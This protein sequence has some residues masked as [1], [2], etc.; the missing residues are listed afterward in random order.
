[1]PK[2]TA[3]AVLELHSQGRRGETTKGCGHGLVINSQALDLHEQ[4]LA[5]K[6]GTPA[7]WL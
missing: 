3:G 7:K 4:N 5:P 1:M 6:F 2:T